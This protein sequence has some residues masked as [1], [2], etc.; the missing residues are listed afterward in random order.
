[1]KIF[2]LTAFLV[3]A[4]QVDSADLDD[5]IIPRKTELFVQLERAVDSRT[6][7]TGDRFQAR[8]TVP[9]AIDD[10]IVIPVGSF[11]LGRV[12]F[13]KK[14]GFLK[15]KAHLKLSFDTVIFPNGV[16]RQISAVVQSAERHTSGLGSKEG[17]ITTPSTQT[18]ET[19]ENAGKGAAAGGAVGGL[20]G[21]S[22]SGVGVGAA[23]GAAAG[24]VLGA[25]KK[26][27]HVNLPR[28]SALTIQLE[29]DVRLVKKQSPPKGRRLIP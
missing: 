12:D 24:A 7:T 23:A 5:V 18:E 13:V 9:V 1:M 3:G 14:P 16:T 8:L 6:A 21:R 27:K 20:A 10:A 19:V 17:Q 26:G 2:L 15:G 22:L 29:D 25:I 11:I 4:L 28:G